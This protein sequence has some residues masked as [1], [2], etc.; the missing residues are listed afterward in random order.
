MRGVRVPFW[1]GFAFWLVVF[2]GPLQTDWVLSSLR[3]P[4][5]VAIAH[6]VSGTVN[7]VGM[8]TRVEGSVIFAET[9]VLKVIPDCDG[10]VLMGC[11]LAAVCAAPKRRWLPVLPGALAGLAV[12]AAANVVR[13][14]LLF[15]VSLEQRAQFD[16][17]HL[18]V[19]QSAMVV[20]TIV[21]WV[22]WAQHASAWLRGDSPVPGG[23][24]RS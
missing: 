16:F 1:V 9:E 17:V 6:V 7:L 11:F 12:L 14:V 8:D 4:A 23:G 13:L 5:C 24:A 2:V 10:L 22:V 18:S 19:T 3:V 21:A 15:F 20:V